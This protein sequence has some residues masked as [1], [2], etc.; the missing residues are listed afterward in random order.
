MLDRHA[1]QGSK[2]FTSSCLMTSGSSLITTFVLVR[3]RFAG[4]AAGAGAGASAW[5]SGCNG[6]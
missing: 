1:F 4:S 5:G 2:E 6:G 3:L